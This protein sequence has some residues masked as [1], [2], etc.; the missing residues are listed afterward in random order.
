MVKIGLRGFCAGCCIGIIY[1]PVRIL[2]KVNLTSI[3]PPRGSGV[4]A[5]LTTAHFLA[6][7]ARS[8]KPTSKVPLEIPLVRITSSNIDQNQNHQTCL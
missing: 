2:S 1:S 7:Q 4:V 3:R 5:H 6:R 8:T